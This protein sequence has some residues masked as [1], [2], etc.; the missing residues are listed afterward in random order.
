MTWN[1][2]GA[3]TGG[4]CPSGHCAQLSSA[5]CGKLTKDLKIVTKIA[6]IDTS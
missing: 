5:F 6:K 1:G 2:P 4:D 3:C